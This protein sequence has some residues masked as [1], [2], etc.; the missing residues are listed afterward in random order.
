MDKYTINTI[1]VSVQNIIENFEDKSNPKN[2]R[3]NN[4]TTL[5]NIVKYCTLSLNKNRIT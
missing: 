4:Q 3:F 5:E 1:P 2:V